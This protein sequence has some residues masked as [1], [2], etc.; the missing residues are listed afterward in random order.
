M[1]RV[2]PPVPVPTIC[3]EYLDLKIGATT[4]ASTG[5]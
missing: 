1:V 2:K 5:F 3:S 4:S